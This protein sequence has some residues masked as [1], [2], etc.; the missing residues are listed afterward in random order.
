MDLSKFHFNCNRLSLRYGSVTIK[1]KFGKVHKY[2]G[3]TL[4]YYTVGQVK[5]TT[6]DYIDEILVA[7]DKAYQIGGG[8]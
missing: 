1:V 7:F 4:D 5:I 8:T 6:L 2:L 3:M